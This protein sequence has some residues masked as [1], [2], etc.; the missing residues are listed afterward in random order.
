MSP[1]NFEKKIKTEEILLERTGFL[2]DPKERQIGV[3]GY[4]K[5]AKGSITRWLPRFF[6]F[7]SDGTI[8]PAEIDPQ[9]RGEYR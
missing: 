9:D 2:R 3:I 1:D 7:N 6:K 5:V 4:M 8:T